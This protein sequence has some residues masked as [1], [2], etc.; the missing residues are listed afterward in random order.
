MTSLI[1]PLDVA[2]VGLIFLPRSLSYFLS[3]LLFVSYRQRSL[4]GTQ[5]NFATY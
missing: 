2:G 4:N 3:S 5:A 1:R